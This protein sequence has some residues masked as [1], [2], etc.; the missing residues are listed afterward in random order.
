MIFIAQKGNSAYPVTRCTKEQ[1]L[2]LLIGR[3]L[4]QPCQLSCNN[5]HCYL[6]DQ[7]KIPEV[8]VTRCYTLM[9]NLPCLFIY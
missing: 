4:L 2:A 8:Q 7:I 6:A 5:A 3:D 9:K 1:I